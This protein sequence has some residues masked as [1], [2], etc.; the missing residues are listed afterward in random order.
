MNNANRSIAFNNFLNDTDVLFGHVNDYWSL[1][2]PDGKS[3]LPRWK[4]Q[5][6]NIGDYYMYDASSLRLRTAEIAYN[7]NDLA[8]VKSAGFSNLRLFL[9]GN[10]L[11]FWSDLPDDRENTY[12]G[13]SATEGA[14][15]TTKRINLGI[16]LTF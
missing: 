9:N 7:L 8:W 5:A 6:E 10:N 11:F 1:D 13:G 15:P 4:T 14:Y 2:N 3:F 12:S 16:E